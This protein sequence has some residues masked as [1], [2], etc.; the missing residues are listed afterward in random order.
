MTASR[1]PLGLGRTVDYHGSH[2]DLH[3]RYMVIYRRPQP[4]NDPRPSADGH[5]YMLCP[6]RGECA[7][8]LHPIEI[9][10][11]ACDDDNTHL[12][13]AVRDSLT[14]VD[15]PVVGLRPEYNTI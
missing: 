10:Y 5:I 7:T 6:N 14:L 11:E 4:P 15:L 12:R 1:S 8:W 9:S 2:L 13:G 3:G